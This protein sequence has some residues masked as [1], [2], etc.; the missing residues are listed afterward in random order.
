MS[1][2]AEMFDQPPKRR[3][4]GSLKWDLHPSDALS[5]LKQARLDE[6]AKM[7]ALL[8]SAIGKIEELSKAAHDLDAAQPDAIRAR[9]KN[10]VEES[11]KLAK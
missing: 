10:Q 2:S 1:V 9:L 11:K 4:T 8:D 6:G 3:G 5:Q 7:A